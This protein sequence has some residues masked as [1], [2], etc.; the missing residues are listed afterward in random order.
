MIRTVTRPRQWQRWVYSSCLLQRAVPP[1]AARQQPRFTTSHKANHFG[2]HQ[3]IAPVTHAPITREDDFVLRS[4]F[5]Y[6][7]FW[8]DFTSVPGGI[9]VGLFRNSFLKEPRG[10]LTFA[11]V[12]L[13][14]ARAVVAKVLAAS[15][16]TEY[17]LI[18]RDLDRLSDIL[19]RVLDMADFVRVTHPDPEIQQNASKA[20]ESVYEYMNEL[21]TMTGLHD[22]LATAMAN[23]DV[24]VVWSEEE[25][26]VAEV[27][28]LDFTKSAVSLPQ[29]YRDRFVQLSS[30]IS[31]VGSAFVQEMAPEQETVVLPSSDLRGMDPVRARDLTRRG[32]VYL[33]TLSGEAVMALRTVH[34]ADARKHIFY[35][36]RTASRRSVQMLEYLMR[37]R[38]ELASLSGFESY[39]HLALRDRMMAKSP[40]AVDQFLRALVESNRPKAMQEM[41]ELLAEKQ[42][43]YPQTNSLDPWDKDYYSDIIRR[44]LRVAG[45]QG[46]LLSSY[47]SLGVPLVGET[48]H[49]DVRRLDVVSDTDGHVAVLYC[50]LFTRPNKSPNPAH[51]T[52]RCSREIFA[53]EME[54]VWEQT[55][56]SN[57][58]SMFGSPELAAT[59]GMTFSRHGDSIK[60]LPTIAL[61]CDFPQPSKHGDQPALLS[62]L[63]LETLF[64]EMGHAIHSV[65]A[66]TS[67]QTVAGT[68]CATD[69]AELPSTLMEFFA[70]DAAVLGQFARHHETNEPLPYRMVAQKARQTRRFEALD[71]ENQIVTAMFDQALHSP[72]AGEPGFDPTAIFHALQRTHSCAPP[73]PPGTSWPGFFGHLSGYGSVYYSYLFDRVLAQ[74]VWDVVFKAGERRAALSRENGEKLK[75]SLLKWGGA[76]D[77][78]KCLAEALDDDRLAEGGEEAM[79][80]VG[81]WGSTKPR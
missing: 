19:C 42:K 56:Q 76:R 30:E 21:N 33:P 15:S 25:K 20:W 50:D 74:R 59:D 49:P 7:Q 24:T 81:S 29:K 51:F 73:D 8:Q 77:P 40:E 27:L 78:W 57:Q 18:V 54:E 11:Y 4:V 14:K 34:D 38:S 22:Q 1:A 17:R 46:D 70:A 10:M 64:H 53:S 68:R 28:K 75:Q 58:K 65:L 32:K 72:R 31:A 69:L 48:W 79:A 61:V 63:Q 26:T 60:Q 41:A 16:V 45:R 2:Y 62:F 9:P 37:L 6:P 52:L 44:P 66:R 55:Q 5:D 47:F 80:L 39:G 23:P 71:T 3:P 67:F 35:A 43:A 12:S 36:S 13:K